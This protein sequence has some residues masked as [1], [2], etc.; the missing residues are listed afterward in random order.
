MILKPLRKFN[1]KVF[2]SFPVLRTSRLELRDIRKN[3]GVAIY[4]MRSNNRVNQF[5]PRP[6][7]LSVEQGEDLALRTAESFA[8]KESIGWAALLRDNKT[9]IGTCGFN[10]IE[11]VNC[12]A[13]IGGEMDTYYSG[14]GIAQEAFEEILNYGMNV[15]HLNTIEAKV[16]PENR[17]AIHILNQ[18]GFKK[19]AHFKNRV[20]YQEQFLDMAVYTLHKENARF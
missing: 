5:I 19:E 17:G 18:T 4:Q 11:T 16:S 3:D 2:D 6:S 1:H 13:E 10:S 7:M 12:H 9:C 8:R 20:F 14:K 15:M